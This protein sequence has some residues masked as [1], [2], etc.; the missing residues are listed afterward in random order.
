MNSINQRGEIPIIMW[1][2]GNSDYLKIALRQAEKYADNVILLGDDKN[3]SFSDH[4]IDMDQYSDEKYNEFKRVY[5]NLSM[6]DDIFE[7]RCFE[8]YFYV[9]E[10]SKKANIERFILCDSDVLLFEN[11]DVFFDDK[12]KAFSHTCSEPDGWAVSPHCALWTMNDM[13]SFTDFLI[14]Y[15]SSNKQILVDCFTKYKANHNK[16][17]ICDMTLLY[18]WLRDSNG[19]YFNTA[20]K[21]SDQNWGGIVASIT[22]FL[23]PTMERKT[24]IGFLGLRDVR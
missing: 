19:K 2:R 6:N 5:V 24:N 21:F 10:Y 18:L 22:Q 11:L 8:R 3:K 20:E 1:H 7:L 16:G 14:K 17:G 13:E 12:T 4:W 9:L 23:Y 15:Y